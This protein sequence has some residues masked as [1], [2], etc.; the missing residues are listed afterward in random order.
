MGVLNVQ[1]CKKIVMGKVREPI[2]KK[3]YNPI[4]LIE[5]LGENDELDTVLNN[6]K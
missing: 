4:Y 6:W 2:V 1:K 3:L 5:K